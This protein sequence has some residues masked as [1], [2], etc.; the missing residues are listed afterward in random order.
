MAEACQLHAVVSWQSKRRP[1]GLS[2]APP[3]CLAEPGGRAGRDV[4][5][6]A[7][8]TA[9][10]GRGRRPAGLAPPGPSSAGARP[11]LGGGG[12]RP[13]AWA[14]VAGQE[15]RLSPRPWCARLN[16]RDCGRPRPLAAARTGR[17][18]CSRR[19]GPTLSPHSHRSCCSWLD[20]S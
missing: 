6:G 12:P 9:A 15:R 8:A 11:R 13:E 10:E 16:G 19:A 7:W 18:G 2:G 17:P 5:E 20:A 14:A 4:V 1:R 3:G